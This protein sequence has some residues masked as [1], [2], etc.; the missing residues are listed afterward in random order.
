MSV[1]SLCDVC[2]AAQAVEFCDRCGAGV[3]RKH[4]DRETGYCTD[5]AAEVGGGQPGTSLR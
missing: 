2:E 1:A 3:C 5:C 4:A